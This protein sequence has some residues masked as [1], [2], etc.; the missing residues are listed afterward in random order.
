MFTQAIVKSCLSME[1]PC[2]PLAGIDRD[3]TDIKKAVE[4]QFPNSLKLFPVE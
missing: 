4:I 3:G 2:N 1:A